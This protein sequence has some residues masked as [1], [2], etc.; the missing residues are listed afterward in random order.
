MMKNYFF[1]FAFLLLLGNLSMAFSAY[2]AAGAASASI[3]AQQAQDDAFL[4]ASAEKGS[5]GSYLTT[6]NGHRVAIP[7][8]E[9][10]CTD[11][12]KDDNAVGFVIFLVVMACVIG[13]FG[14]IFMGMR[15]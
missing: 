14:I 6:V 2:V 5:Y 1:L 9:E 7:C 13:A 4:L 3:A 15:G 8:K 10:G 12:P 11:A